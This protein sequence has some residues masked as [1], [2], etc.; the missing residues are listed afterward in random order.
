MTRVAL[1]ADEPARAKSVPGAPASVPALWFEYLP[2]RMPALRVKRVAWLLPRALVHAG[3]AGFERTHAG[4]QP[5][6]GSQQ[7]AVVGVELLQ[8]G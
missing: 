8:D 1:K 7:F 4:G 3:E 2:A 5:L 6:K